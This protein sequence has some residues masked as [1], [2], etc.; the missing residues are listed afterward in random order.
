M[1]ESLPPTN[2]GIDGRWRFGLLKDTAS[3]SASTSEQSATCAARPITGISR[4]HLTGSP[5]YV[6]K[7][8][9][10]SVAPARIA[11]IGITL[12][13]GLSDGRGGAAGAPRAH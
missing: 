12:E 11:P 8:D 7:P 13:A 2:R 4:N 6:P 10:S 1:S 9:G 3:C 5:A